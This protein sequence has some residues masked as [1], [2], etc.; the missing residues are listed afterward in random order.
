MIGGGS[1]LLHPSDGINPRLS[2]NEPNQFTFIYSDKSRAF[3]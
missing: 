1:S 2:C 3:R